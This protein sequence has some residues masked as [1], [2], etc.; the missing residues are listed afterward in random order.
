MGASISYKR[1]DGKENVGIWHSPR[2][3]TRQASS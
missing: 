1:P 2:V 3:L